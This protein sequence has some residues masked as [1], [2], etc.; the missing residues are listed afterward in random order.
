MHLSTIERRGA[1]T[2][3]EFTGERV[4]MEPI[5][6]GV[7]PAHLRRWVG[8]LSA[9]LAGMSSVPELMY[10]MIDQQELRAG[11]FHRRPGVHV[12]GYWVVGG[13][14][15]NDG[16]VSE[17]AQPSHS[18]WPP[19]HKATP[20]KPVTVP[21]H[22]G[23]PTPKHGG[24]PTRHSSNSSTW[25]SATFAA[26]EALLLASNVEACRAFVGVC[27]GGVRDGGDCAAVD[28]SG[29]TVVPMLA[30]RCYAGTVGT[31]H[32]SL[33]VPVDCRRTVVRLNIPGVN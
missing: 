24:I 3:P 28:L 22:S 13:H 14:I 27:R 18:P 30:G 10:L 2:F 17:P 29:M 33:P 6:R 4:Y 11:Q 21:K 12:D 7:L 15:G 31:L 20:V 23:V 32:E 25:E 1:V 9:M 16:H 5:R 19:S 8:T 26:P